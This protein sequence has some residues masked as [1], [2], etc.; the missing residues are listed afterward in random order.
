MDFFT[1][2]D[3]ARRNTGR[4][5]LFFSLAV[6][7]LVIMT[8]LLVMVFFGY[9]RS[10]GGGAAGPAPFDWQLFC[11]VGLGVVAVVATGSLYKIAALSS[12]GDA[13]ATML[14]GEPIFGDNGDPDQRRVINVV[15]EMAIAAGTPVPQVYLLKESGINAFAA[16]FS[17]SDAV[18]GITSGAI[19]NLNREQLQGVIAHEFSHILNGDMRLNIRL[20][21]ILHG[22]LL[23]GLIGYRI[24]RGTSRTSG[25]RKGFGP[26]LLMGAGLMVIGYAGT[27]FGKLIKAAVSRQRE[28]LADAA[29]V[30]FTRNPDGI[31]G[32]LLCI[33]ARPDGSLLK[34]PRCAEI[35]H[36]FFG[37]G[38]AVFFESLF[39]TH[40][41]LEARIKRI[42]PGWDGNFPSGSTVAVAQER[43]RHG[44]AEAE[45]GAVMGLTG[46]AMVAKVGQLGEAELG[47][48]RILLRGIPEVLQKA[49]RDPFAARALICFLILDGDE[50]VRARQLQ[51]LKSSADRG[52][53]LETLKLIRAGGALRPEQ[54]LPLVDLALP[55]LRRLTEPQYRLFIS[56]LDTLIEADG[57]ISLF[58]W[59]LRRIVLHHLAKAFGQPAGKGVAGGDLN[60]VLLSMLAHAGNPQEGGAVAAFT[61]ARKELAL[62]I[63][64][65]PVERIGLPELDRALVDLERLAPQL[66]GRLLTACG[67]CVTADGLIAPVEAELL[68]A[69]AA[70]LD[71]PIPPLVI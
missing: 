66:K 55:T 11:Y 27:F 19:R 57:R 51:H 28:F 10:R 54:R 62:E 6:F 21:G 44:N 26:L 5:V 67:A 47:Y 59:C 32:A 40:P 9:F 12:G 37:Q 65:A 49:A 69:V 53:H 50:A 48:A 56:N 64:L 18:I 7:F 14:G 70:T 39:A 71:C 4:L 24:L 43:P 20:I 8:N 45:S 38:V 2:Q 36:A 41:P 29:A 33:G 16:G 34:N 13:V 23:I 30:Q 61:A 52:V 42:L 22:I 46:A 31:G 35:S 58:E 3:Q 68:R 1:A 60:Q 15:E 17:S 25:A 63:E